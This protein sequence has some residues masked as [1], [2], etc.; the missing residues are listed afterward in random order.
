MP[1]PT[2]GQGTVD[3]GSVTCATCRPSR[4]TRLRLVRPAPASSETAISERAAGAFEAAGVGCRAAP[5][6]AGWFE[7]WDWPQAASAT[8]SPARGMGNLIFELL[9]LN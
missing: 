8:T 9:D 2:C 4:P 7:G 5:V 6:E 1:P 3:S